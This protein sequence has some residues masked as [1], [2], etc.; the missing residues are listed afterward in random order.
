MGNSTLKN[1]RHI[2]SHDIINEGDKVMKLSVNLSSKRYVLEHELNGVRECIKLG[3]YPIQKNLKMPNKKNSID[4]NEYLKEINAY[5]A[6]MCPSRQ[7]E[8]FDLYYSAMGI[9]DSQMVDYE[10][11]GKVTSLFATIMDT[12]FGLGDSQTTGEVPAF[13]E[14]LNI[15]YPTT[16]LADYNSDNNRKARATTYIQSEYFGL[17]CVALVC[18]GMAPLWTWLGASLN[19]ADR[20]D[21]CARD[22]TILSTLEKT[23]FIK[24]EWVLRLYEMIV[25]QVEALEDSKTLIAKVGGAGS[26]GIPPFLLATILINKLSTCIIAKA[27]D[28]NL[29]VAAH[30]AVGNE[31]KRYSDNLAK[32]CE[33][34]D[35]RMSDEEGKVGFLE[36]Y[37]TRQKVSDDIYIVNS[38]YLKNYRQVK[39]AL[40]S[41]I[42]NSL[43]KQCLESLEKHAGFTIGAHQVT[44]CQ[45]VLA[46]SVRVD[47]NTGTRRRLIMPRALPHVNREAILSAMAVTQAALIS[48][49]FPMIAKYISAIPSLKSEEE[50]ISD[51]PPAIYDINAET[52]ASLNKTHPYLRP[53]GSK[54]Q[55]ALNMA[56][57]NIDSY[58]TSILKPEMYNW[59]ISCEPNVAKALE[60]PNGP[61]EIDAFI[62]TELGKLISFIAR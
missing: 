38:L 34:S 62:K 37:A 56:S 10:V 60:V 5:F 53:Q 13:I 55:P 54:T 48:W 47:P 22:S 58:V 14:S 51:I 30:T 9:M 52:K 59:K 61:F 20:G 26:D 39:N 2:L 24:H 8:L 31:L 3:A 29:I 41:D 6:Q 36:A 17:A 46:R 7:D 16:V 33:R 57:I 45:I 11:I 50:I 12:Y 19:S 28:K 42:S 43:V 25:Y 49:K 1:N 4:P 23:K 27:V 40:D 35:S 32:I 15:E 21:I 18:H 44:L